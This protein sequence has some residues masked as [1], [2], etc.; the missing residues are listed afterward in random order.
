MKQVLRPTHSPPGEPAQRSDN[1]AEPRKSP[2]YLRGLPVLLL[3]RSEARVQIP[4]S[5]FDG[6]HCLNKTRDT[7]FTTICIKHPLNRIPI[8]ISLLSHFHFTA[9]SLSCTPKQNRYLF[10]NKKKISQ[11]QEKFQQVLRRIKD[12]LLQYIS[13]RHSLKLT[14]W[15]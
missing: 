1:P 6:R 15:A 14:Q 9:F 4:S 10:T 2:T 11:L 7:H 5:F 13:H 3:P 8:L 12:V